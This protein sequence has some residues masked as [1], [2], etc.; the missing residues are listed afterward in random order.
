V[1]PASRCLF[2]IC[3]E[4]SREISQMGDALAVKRHYINNFDW[5]DSCISDL[6]FGRHNDSSAVSATE[7]SPREGKTIVRLPFAM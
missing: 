2:P 3:N 4:I 7:L 6:R 1:P 5:Q